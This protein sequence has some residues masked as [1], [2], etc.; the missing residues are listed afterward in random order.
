MDGVSMGVPQPPYP[1]TP[2]RISRRCQSPGSFAPAV[3]LVQSGESD[4]INCFVFMGTLPTVTLVE[5][6]PLGTR[7]SKPTQLKA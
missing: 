5:A 3:L 6:R 2:L 7:T 4:Q 1:A